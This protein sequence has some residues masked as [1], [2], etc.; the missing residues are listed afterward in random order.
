MKDFQILPHTADI[1]IRAYGKTLQELFK[2]ALIGMFTSIKPEIPECKYETDRIQCPILPEERMISLKSHN[3]DTLLVDFLSEAWYL[4]DVYNEVY[5]D[6]K[7]KD[8]SE[9]KIDA[10]LYGIK[11]K[12]FEEGEIKAVTYHGLKIKKIDNIWQTDILFDI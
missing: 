4:S 8:F 12:G 11:I 1:K 5:L 7:I 3:V 10:F 9:N 6:V 2:N